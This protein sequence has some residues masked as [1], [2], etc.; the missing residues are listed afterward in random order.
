MFRVGADETEGR[1]VYELGNGQWDI[2]E[3]RL[4]LT[5]L[6]PRNQWVQDF[7]IHHDY[8]HIGPKTMLLNARRIDHVDLILLALEDITEQKAA[9]TLLHN[10]NLDLKHFAYAAS[11]DLQEPLRTVKLYTQLLAREYK[12]KLDA[13]GDEFIV[14][15]I[16]AASQVEMLLR[17][18]R[19]YWLVNEPLGNLVPVDCEEVLEKTMQA[20]RV[21]LT[22]SRAI[23]THDPLP[24]VSARQA[25]LAM[26]FQNLLGNAIKYQRPGEQP[27]VHVAA[28]KKG[29]MWCFSVKDNGIGIETEHLDKIFAP[30]KRL[31]GKDYPGTGIGLA[32][33]KKIVDRYK[34]E[35]WA[36]S[37][38]GRE[39]TF[40][41][42]IPG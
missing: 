10:L 2:P 30:F 1:L 9:E 5:E 26:L 13:K 16:E 32:L 6:L 8:A 20:L 14:G 11:H 28:E 36:E 4:L 15:T 33:C 39:S 12:G 40:F 35:L 19:E 24:T 23:V 21:P 3:L 42:T 29:H 41:F 27:R 38:P 25:G 18:L 34:G 37:C 22:E 31:H 17:D 7:E